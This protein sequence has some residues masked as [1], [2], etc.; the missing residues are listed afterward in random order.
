M[1]TGRRA[2][3]AGPVVCY[4]FR[5]LHPQPDGR[6]LQADRPAPPHRSR[7]GPGDHARRHCCRRR[8]AGHPGVRGERGAA[9]L[10]RRERGPRRPDTDSTALL[11]GR[12]H[13][14]AARR[15][16]RRIPKY[17]FTVEPTGRVAFFR[18]ESGERDA[19][20]ARAGPRVRDRDVVVAQRRRPS[21]RGG[22]ERRTCVADAGAV[23][24]AVRRRDAQGPQHRRP[25][26]GHH[27]P[28]SQP[29]RHSADLL[30]RTGRPEIRRRT[31]RRHEI[32][33]A[34]TDADGADHQARLR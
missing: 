12:R 18:V 34:W 11:A 2:V 25:R 13:G 10:W 17:V 20:S 32:A 31:R 1:V 29:P 14:R 8:R 26:R 9:A 24:A 23:R 21:S 27:R 6:R 5:T 7:R 33:Y 3:D 19:G 28:R 16:R 15:R 4:G 22:P 30:H